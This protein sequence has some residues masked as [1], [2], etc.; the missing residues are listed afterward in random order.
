MNKEKKGDAN[1]VLECYSIMKEAMIKTIRHC[2][3]FSEAYTVLGMTVCDFLSVTKDQSN[4]SY[5]ELVD[6]FAEFLK[7]TEKN[8]TSNKNIN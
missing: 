6:D 8:R 5:A 3:N 7:E 2:G 1:V 4:A